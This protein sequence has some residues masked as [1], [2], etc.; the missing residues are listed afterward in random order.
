MVSSEVL[1]FRQLDWHATK[2]SGVPGDFISLTKYGIVETYVHL[3]F[4]SKYGLRCL[5]F[6]RQQTKYG[7][8][9]SS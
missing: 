9:K 4:L 1:Y 8:V 5:I 3:S 7:F 6:S 2:I